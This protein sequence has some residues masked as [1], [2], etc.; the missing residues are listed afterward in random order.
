MN[1]GLF[2]YQLLGLVGAGSFVGE[3]YRTSNV[4]TVN[5][6]SFLASFLAGAFL[7]YLVALAIYAVSRNKETTL[8]LGGLLAYQDEK[9]ISRIGRKVVSE[10][11]HE[12]GGGGD[13]PH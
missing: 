9:H 7:A 8:I 11:M 6:R 1:N 4:E 13:G 3:F 12:K 5:L 10:W 2:F